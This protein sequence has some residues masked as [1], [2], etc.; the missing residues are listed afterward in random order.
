ME[1]RYEKNP[2]VFGGAAMIKVSV[3]DS[4]KIAGDSCQLSIKSGYIYVLTHPS[5][6]DLFKVGMT[7]QTP[8]KRLAQHNSNFNKPAGRIV[9]ETGQR[10][11]LKEYH[12]VEDPLYAEKAFWNHIRIPDI[13]FQGRD[14]IERMTWEQVQAGIKLA[15][16]AG[17]RPQPSPIALEQPNYV[18]ANSA[19]IR[20]RLEGR[21][22]TLLTYV[23]SMR[24]GKADFRCDNGHVWREVPD[25]VGVGNGCPFCGIGQ[26]DPEVINQHIKPGYIVLLIHPNKP[27]YL[28]V[29][30][31]FGSLDSR[32]EEW[33][34]GDW[35][36]H[37]YRYCEEMELAEEFIWDLLGLPLPHERNQIKFDLEAAEEA[38]RK[39][40]YAVQD[41]VAENERRLERNAEISPL[42]PLGRRPPK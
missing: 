2:R 28:K 21:G 16:D 42:T 12:E 23:K 9:K 6:P 33:P 35:E 18:Y 36:T 8:Q 22:I 7:T 5:D 37:R 32:F 19:R 24:S 34:W 29:G 39:L 14:E 31:Y 30:L 27:G 15:L 10:W 17:K 1:W 40:T 41:R 3:H 4:K 26:E 25:T 13:P 38:F 20:R 11:V